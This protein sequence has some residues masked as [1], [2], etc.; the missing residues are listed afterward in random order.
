[1]GAILIRNTIVGDLNEN[2]LLSYS[3]LRVRVPITRKLTILLN[4][5]AFVERESCG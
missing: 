3:S 2:I 4:S 5:S 1:M